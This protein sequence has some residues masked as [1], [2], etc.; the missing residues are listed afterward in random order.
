MK[1]ETAVSLALLVLYK[2]SGQTSIGF[3]EDLVRVLLEMREAGMPT[4]GLGFKPTPEGIESDE[5]IR[6]IG[7]LAMGGYL[8]QESPIR[9]TSYGL[10]LLSSEV[11]EHASEPAVS[12]AMTHLGLTAEDVK[13]VAEAAW[14]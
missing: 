7:R 4:P 2:R 10:D 6:F 12:R 13:G 1:P 11:Q 8:V 5:V 14:A 9:L 3:R